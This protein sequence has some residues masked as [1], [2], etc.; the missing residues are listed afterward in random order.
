[1]MSKQGFIMALVIA[2]T[3][4]YAVNQSDFS[5]ISSNDLEPLDRVHEE[6]QIILATQHLKKIVSKKSPEKH[7]EK[8]SN[9]IIYSDQ[10]AMDRLRLV[11]HKTELQEKTVNEYDNFKRYPPQN[12]AINSKQQDPIT[13]RYD[14]DERTTMNDDG[15]VGLTIW[16]DEK[17]YVA[18]N[19]VT[20]FAYL[21][22]AQGQRIKGNYSARLLSD[23]QDTL[24]EFIL[25]D[26]DNDQLYEAS[27]ELNSE[28][29]ENFTPGIYKV[30]IEESSSDI[31]DALTFTLSQPDIRLTG[32]FKDQ[33]NEEGGLLIEA[34]V[35]VT[36][37]SQYYIQASLY[38]ATHV[39][40]G[41]TQLNQTLTTGKHW[42]ALNFAGLMI[43]DS[44]ESGPYVLQQMSLAKVTMPMQR[45]PLSEP[46]FQTDSYGLDEFSNQTYQ[47]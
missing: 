3:L 29:T 15:T 34:Q 12:S 21:Q 41:I 10:S 18:G 46:N 11:T 5:L 37:D 19:N 8:S 23:Q 44:Q 16:S 26:D 20:M 31:K 6:S 39:A 35:E 22:D 32:E 2:S 7:Q 25:Q 28:N 13:Q 42:V 36:Q 14:V 45:A 47:P 17:Y 33:I 38:S 1:M 43:Q 24:A 9:S 4:V 30:I 27:I 40:I